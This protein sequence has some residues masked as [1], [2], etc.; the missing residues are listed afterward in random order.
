MSRKRLSKKQL[1]SDRFVEQTFDWMHWAETH[2]PQVVAALVGLVVLVAALFVYRSMSRGS[3][4]RASG[5]YLEAR[6]A[7]FAGNYPLAASDLRQFLQRHG[8][9]S[10]ADDARFFLA[11]ALYEA[12]QTE[13][14]IRALQEFLDRHDDSPF[15]PNARLLLAAAYARSGQTAQAVEAY[16]EALEEAATDFQRIQV[17]QA[18][19]RVYEQEERLDEAAAAY[20]AI[21]EIDPEGPLA[22]EAR[23]ELAEL[24]VRPIGAIAAA[25]GDTTGGTTTPAGTGAEAPVTGSGTP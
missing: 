1:K 2:R 20:R 11:D 25:P 19:A 21:L 16:Q 12:G 18:L 15:A 5:E 22:D 3:E 10:Y 17:Q 7:Y 8:R 24:T 13:E 4:E 23:R 14:A 9:T 6:Q